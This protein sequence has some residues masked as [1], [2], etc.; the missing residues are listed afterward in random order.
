AST[1]AE[2]Q[3]EST[4]NFGH[5]RLPIH[6]CF[7]VLDS[8]DG[9]SVRLILGRRKEKPR[10]RVIL[11]DLKIKPRLITGRRDLCEKSSIFDFDLHFHDI[12]F[13]RAI[14]IMVH[15]S[16]SEIPTNECLLRDEFFA[17]VALEIEQ[18]RKIAEP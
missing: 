10:G 7:L 15:I 5:Q 16:K 4:E 8:T 13:L 9:S 2:N 14:K 18:R 3:P 6:D 12:L 1:T 11:I 17:G